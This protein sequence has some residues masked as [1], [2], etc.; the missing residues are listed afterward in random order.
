MLA[1]VLVG[2][3][4]GLYLLAENYLDRQVEERI[5]TVLNTLGGIAEVD[6]DGIEWKPETRSVNLDF[7]VLGD[8]VVW[9]IADEN[10]QAV[11]RSKGTHIESFL[12]DGSP[13]IRF[14]PVSPVNQGNLKWSG[15]GWE[16]GQ[17]RIRSDIRDLD[18]NERQKSE[19]IDDENRYR[20]ISVTVG[21]SLT[22]V[23]TTLN[24][25]LITLVELTIGIWIVAFAAGRFVCRRAL[26]PIH[27]MAVAARQ[28]DASDL[29]N[30]RLPSVSSNDELDELNQAFNNLLD[31]LQESFE[32]QKRFTDDASHQLRTP[33]TAMLGQIEV[34]LRRERRG[35]DYRQVLV[36]VQQKAGHLAQMV[37]S[38]LF[39]AR[40]NPE[41]QAPALET[42]ELTKWLPQHI[43]T[44][45]GHPRFRDITCKVA[46]TKPCEINAQ[47][48][49]LSELLNVLID[50]AC[51]YSES[52]T[53]VKVQL[54]K[55]AE[56]VSIRV[57]DQGCGIEESDLAKL[58]V[59]FF[60]SADAR[61]R[62]IEGVGLGL[63]IAKR[64]VTM[65]D[66][67]LTV[68][69]NRDAVCCFTL[70][71]PL[72]ASTGIDDT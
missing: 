28:I 53:P 55:L 49:L 43:H 4:L 16:F 6:S 46:T 10:G 25:L 50:N 11:G 1:V 61:R 66:G 59:P 2:F 70:R 31:R 20:A 13:S 42:L 8:H 69:R 44:W 56:E 71:F 34:A 30:Q 14:S 47:P 62:G 17:R 35:E 52:G 38:L 54:E 32:R 72:I 67:S 5:D 27:R 45:A 57:E 64:L 48:V 22:S 40:T 12:P 7:S 63:S 15:S 21:I 26:L 60:R 29:T 3:S 33:I 9:L 39:L 41:A 65:F 23:R 24:R 51:K 68:T 19:S 37:E 18:E 58:F 36:T